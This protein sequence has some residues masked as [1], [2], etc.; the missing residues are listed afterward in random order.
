M[1]EWDERGTYIH[2]DVL[3]LL[4]N[5]SA[6]DESFTL[7]DTADGAI[8][9]SLIDTATY[10]GTDL[11]ATRLGV[12]YTLKGRSLALLKQRVADPTEA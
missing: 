9:E 8:W 11:A 7:P 10:T 5:G 6:G 3:L 2:D 4:L 12:A 1:R